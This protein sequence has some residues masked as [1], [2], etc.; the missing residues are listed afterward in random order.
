MTTLLFIDN[1]VFMVVMCFLTMAM[2]G[3][4]R[5]AFDVPLF[6]SWLF[7]VNGVVDR[8]FFMLVL[9]HRV[10]MFVSV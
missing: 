1:I 5:L 9:W 3:Y 6:V 10:E 7:F 2:F 8:F 4:K